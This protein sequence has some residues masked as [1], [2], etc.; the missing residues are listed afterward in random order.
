MPWPSVLNTFNRPSTTSR[1]DN[2]SHS[3]L[4][5]TVSSAVGQIEQT[6]GLSTTSLVGTLFYDIRSPDS[7]GGGHVQTANK[8]G[9]GQTSFTKGD[10]L[11]ATS[12]SVLAKLAVG[13][14][15]QVLVSD[16]SVAAG[17]KWGTPPGI[18]ATTIASIVSIR[19]PSTTETS[20]FSITIPGSTLGTNN[21]IRAKSY[22][23]IQNLGSG[24]STM[25]T[26]NYGGSPVASV[27]LVPIANSASFFG[28][29]EGTLIGNGDAAAQRA[30]ISLNAAQSN[31]SPISVIA[32]LNTKTATIESSA[33]QTFGM[34][35]RP[36]VA[37]INVDVDGT[38]V[39]KIL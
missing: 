20:L 26:L 14:D 34:T 24:A 28:I 18:K 13:P 11:V 35:I 29:L 21:A 3:A 17:L 31:A 38:I 1:L 36:I 12:S 2:P 27:V 8:G 4:H 22:I 37:G 32:L 7:D 16:S 33:N 30:I 10:V 15:G 39:E 19:S 9:T 5:N 23:E 6:I 25:A